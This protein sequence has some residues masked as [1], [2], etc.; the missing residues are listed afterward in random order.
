VGNKTS[1]TVPGLP[2]GTTYYFTV[3]AYGQDG[4]ESDP[5]SERFY[6]AAV[7]APKPAVGLFSGET[8]GGSGGKHLFAQ[9]VM[10]PGR[11]FTARVI[12]GDAIY[13]L[14]GTLSAAGKATVKGRPATAGDQPLD[15]SV[16]LDPSGSAISV[17]VNDGSGD[18]EVTTGPSAFSAKSQTPAAGTYTMRVGVLTPDATPG[19]NMTIPQGWGFAR[20]V[21]AK[22]GQVRVTGRLAD[23]Q[24]FSASAAL[25][26]NGHFFINSVMTYKAKGFLAGELAIRDTPG[27]SDGDGVLFWHKPAQPAGWYRTGLSGSMQAQLSMY[28]PIKAAALPKTSFTAELTGG[29]LPG[30][31]TPLLRNVRFANDASLIVLPPGTD[32]LHVRANPATGLITGTFVHPTNGQL[33]AISGVLFEKDQTGSGFFQGVT[34]TGNFELTGMPALPAH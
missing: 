8:T 34:Q 11:H 25:D 1:A 7:G 21:I 14:R 10:A 24:P 29:D 13:A 23:N 27:V 4:L 33:R 5:S 32:R 16:S 28:H 9:V 6:V 20:L 15:F 18:Y 30:V 19:A 22:T 17:S 31:I 12:L 2:D 3:T 26:A